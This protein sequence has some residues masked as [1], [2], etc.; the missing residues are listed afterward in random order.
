MKIN[1]LLLLLWMPVASLLAQPTDNP[2]RTFYPQTPYPHFTDSIAWHRVWS[3]SDFEDTTMVARY[4]KARDFVAQQGGGVLFF[5]AGTYQFENS[6]QI[7]SG[8]V[9]RGETP[10]FTIAKDSLFAPSTRFVFPRYIPTD[11]GLGTPNSTAFKSI[12]AMAH[13]SNA[14]MVYVDV[15]RASVSLRSQTFITVQTPRGST[16]RS[17]EENR[18]LILFGI[19][20]NNVAAPYNTVPAATQHKWQRFSSPF[21]SNLSI[22]AWKNA[23]IANCRINDF[24]RNAIHPIQNLSFPQPGYLAERIV[25]GQTVMDTLQGHQAMFSYTDHNGISM[26]RKAT[27][28]NAT[29]EEEPGNFCTGL[30]IRD[31]W[32]YKTMRVGIICSGMGIVVDNNTLLDDP[33]KQIWLHPHGVRVATNNAATYEN[34]G[35]DFGGWNVQLTRNDIY[36]FRHKILNGPYSSVDGEGILMQECCGGT[37]VNGAYIAHNHTHDTYIGLWKVRDVNH[38]VIDS[39]NT[40]SEGII[41]T[42]NVGGA[43]N[44]FGFYSI[45]DSKIRGNISRFINTD[46]NRGGRNLLIENNT[47]TGT[48]GSISAPCFA[49]IVNNTGYSNIRYTAVRDTS[50]GG[51]FD[52][53]PC[54][55]DLSRYPMVWLDRPMADDTL[56]EAGTDQ[57]IRLRWD[58]GTVDSLFF[59]AN[60]QKIGAALPAQNEWIWN[61]GPCTQNVPYYIWASVK[62]TTRN[63]ITRT[64]M[65]KVTP[66]CLT[67]EK[68]NLVINSEPVLFPNPSNGIFFL[69]NVDEETHIQLFDYQGKIIGFNRL[70]PRL[71]EVKDAKPGLYMILIQQKEKTTNRRIIIR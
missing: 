11:T 16:S 25:N 53:S 70:N 19:R 23:C 3:I 54:L 56:V 46:G 22:Y 49:T 64:A 24:E 30:E 39:N 41:L 10:L 21:A 12:S 14:G 6:I 69:Q 40:G 4:N 48:G 65:K 42:A 51:L 60:T 32:I 35:I 18:N 1:L 52:T 17:V 57:P 27:I 37:S 28:T 55:P 13:T 15:D 62:D 20:S 71:L 50:R 29:P 67:A 63:T 8:V 61:A 45:R 59:Y 58:G 66:I 43:G 68:S 34:R 9:I 26:N 31:N 38:V 36:V 7:R 33:G 47:S 44:N 2:Y 5:P